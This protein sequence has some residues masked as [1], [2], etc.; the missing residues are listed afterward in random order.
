MSKVAVIL[1][2]G[3]NCEL[4][5]IQACRRAKMTPELIRWN[6]ASKNLKTY[7]AII[8]P[9]GFSYEDRGRS[10]VIAAQDPIM[11]DIKNE[12]LKGKPV[13]GVCN[14]AQILVESGLIPDLTNGLKM[15]L[16]WN[17]R[18]T[19]E[20]KLVGIGYYNDWIY[21]RSNAP[22]FRSPYNGFSNKVIMRIPVAHGEGRFTCKD[23]NTLRDL[24]ENK[25]VL[26]QY[27]D[28]KGNITDGFPINTNNA[29]YN[30]AGVCNKE[31]NVLA[32]MPHPE[33]TLVGQPI[34]DSLAAFLHKRKKIP[35]I[36]KT[37]GKS[38]SL[39]EKIKILAKKPDIA[40]TV[41]LII[42]DNEEKTIESTLR[43]KGFKELKLC[44]K[45]YY[46]V[47]ADSSA[48][49]KN[50]AKQ[51]IES[52]EFINLNKETVMVEMDNKTWNYEKNVG[53]VEKGDK[54][55]PP[56]QLL[57][58]SIDKYE[59]ESVQQKIEKF[60]KKGVVAKVIKGVLWEISEQKKDTLATLVSSHIINNPHSMYL[61][62]FV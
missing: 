12:A 1:F 19:K 62:I 34:F 3:T 53:L 39:P 47:Y 15:A 31:G 24:L 46:G 5:M 44:R 36:K 42:T 16:A 17:E 59:S 18:V 26:F 45:R 25:Q 56:H 33:R 13:L 57:V 55:T 52:G 54:K 48:D 43:K 40:I 2:P 21:I 10:G 35:V 22:A 38:P 29:I 51:I 28:R 58:T 41:R 23:K 60:C 32:L 14:G 4:E 30:L 50:L 11:K 61:M 6:D 8:I 7:D 9:G 20:G 49:K 37:A 27:C